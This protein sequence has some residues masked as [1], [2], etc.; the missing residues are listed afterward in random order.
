MN[1]FNTDSDM[2]SIQ[3]R[4]FGRGQ[5]QPNV[6][7]HPV[8][9]TPTFPPHS[10]PTFPPTTPT[11]PTSPTPTYPHHTYPANPGQPTFPQLNNPFINPMFHPQPVIRQSDGQRHTAP[12]TNRGRPQRSQQKRAPKKPQPKQSPKTPCFPFIRS[13][14]LTDFL[15]AAETDLQERNINFKKV[16]HQIPD[17]NFVHVEFRVDASH[18]TQ[19]LSLS[20]PIGD[21]TYSA[22]K[23]SGSLLNPHFYEIVLT[24]SSAD[25]FPNVNTATY[26]LPGVLLEDRARHTLVLASDHI[27]KEDFVNSQIVM[28]EK[29]LIV[30][31]LKKYAPNL[32]APKIT[33]SEITQLEGQSLK[34]LFLSKLGEYSDWSKSKNSADL[35]QLLTGFRSVT[36]YAMYPNF[37][38]LLGFYQVLALKDLSRS[39]KK[40]EY[41]RFL[42]QIENTFYS[43]DFLSSLALPRRQSDTMSNLQCRSDDWLGVTD[44]F[45]SIGILN[46]LDPHVLSYTCGTPAL[47]GDLFRRSSFLI[48]V[49]S[50]NVSYSDRMST[51]QSLMFPLTD[52]VIV[53][54]NVEIFRGP[55]SDCYNRLPEPHV[56]TILSVV[57][58]EVIQFRRN[59]LEGASVE[60]FGC[61]KQLR[62]VFHRLFTFFYSSIK[63][64]VQI[65]VITPALWDYFHY[66][67]HSMY[68]QL[69]L[70]CTW[71]SPYFNRIVLSCSQREFDIFACALTTF[72]LSTRPSPFSH[73]CLPDNLESLFVPCTRGSDCPYSSSLTHCF[74]GQH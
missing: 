5:E 11:Y 48:A 8:Y 31:C 13:D 38:L 17:Y 44:D 54:E 74:L 52:D 41:F 46:F 9:N 43:F 58:E 30:V 32:L 12:Q 45:N 59:T 29:R 37:R 36:H 34:S 62:N 23:F 10:T 14:H 61:I 3:T 35:G 65:L 73:S 16:V 67:K 19:T 71:F 53:S 66:P 21:V 7:Q 51:P 49:D 57:A 33:N 6:H 55:P 56:V 69:S 40:N 60:D 47:H 42:A 15:S 22:M 72:G 25:P 2:G 64:G 39:L 20:Y 63:H 24:S 26:S 18:H 1:L 28:G 68:V 4:P 27:V 70:L 50:G